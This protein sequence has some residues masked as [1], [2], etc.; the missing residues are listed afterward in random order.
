[1]FYPRIDNCLQAIT[2]IEHKYTPVREI[3]LSTFLTDG[4]AEVERTRM[5]CTRPKRVSA[6]HRKDLEPQA[7]HVRPLTSGWPTLHKESL[8]CK[9]WKRGWRWLVTMPGRELLEVTMQKGHGLRDAKWHSLIPQRH[10]RQGPVSSWGSPG[11]AAKVINGIQCLLSELRWPRFFQF[12]IF[13][14]SLCP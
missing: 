8:T 7:P 9:K 10:L 11:L 5:T 12:C 2:V 13:R 1:M 4:K 6:R 3:L 14:M